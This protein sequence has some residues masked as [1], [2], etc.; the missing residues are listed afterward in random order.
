MSK[1][2]QTIPNESKIKIRFESV[3]I[4]EKNSL[5]VISQCPENKKKWEEIGRTKF[6]KKSLR[7]DYQEFFLVLFEFY[8][9]QNIKLDFHNQAKPSSQNKFGSVTFRLG[10]LMGKNKKKISVN[11]VNSQDKE[12]TVGSLSII[13]EEIKIENMSISMTWCGQKLKKERFGSV[14]PFLRF[15]K[16]LNGNQGYALVHETEVIPKSQDPEWASFEIMSYDLCNCE[17]DREIL[18][19][20]FDKKKKGKPNLIGVVVT[21]L[22][23]LMNENLEIFA[24]VDPK[25]KKKKSNLG[26]LELSN[27]T[28]KQ[29]HSLLDFLSSNIDLSIAIGVD[30]TISN[31]QPNIPKS[32]HYIN[33]PNYNQYEQT[34]V[35]LCEVLNQYT[36]T[37][38]IAAFGF[39]AKIQSKNSVIASDLFPLNGNI[40]DPECNGVEGVLS[41]YTT[42]LSFVG[43]NGPTKFTPL[44]TC[45]SNISK[46]SRYFEYTVLILI[47][48]GELVDES[49]TKKN[50]LR[51]SK[52][53]ISIVIV[54]VGD[55]G[56]FESMKFLPS[57][58]YAQ[59]SQF[60]RNLINLVS[61]KESYKKGDFTKNAF[62]GFSEQFLRYYK[63]A[64]KV[65]QQ[66]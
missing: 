16:K 62:N 60:K 23:S 7:P 43:L 52:L 14:N 29:T 59:E 30:F 5:I 63:N 40:F 54:C 9:I 55:T 38:K 34:I 64:K 37:D 6:Y 2:T 35:T 19:E 28:E 58:Q 1:E 21:T 27:F 65:P 45:A 11:I 15:S 17:Y 22:L 12:E 13:G 10:E 18:I 56:C 8:R 20:C 26:L 48:D 49:T 47:T 36:K 61:F 42:S 25:K 39:G 41:A 53:P 57:E 24:L 50:L 3:K 32:L 51:A 46:A 44:I 4:Q 66:K 31:G 33:P